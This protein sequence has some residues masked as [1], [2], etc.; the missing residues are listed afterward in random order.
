MNLLG[1]DI[2][3]T[4]TKV[5]LQA[6]DGGIVERLE[7]PTRAVEGPGALAARLAELFAKWPEAEGAG[8]SVAGLMDREK[9]L[10][11]APNLTEFVGTD[12]RSAFE[13]FGVLALE[14]DVNCAVYGEWQVG[15]GRG[16]SDLA[17][18]SLG[19]GVGGG[20]ILGGEL[21]HGS[22][23]LGAELGHMTL[24]PE[25]PVCPCGLRGHV[26]SWLGS[27]GFAA[28][29]RR[30]AEAAPDSKLAAAIGNGEEPDA[31][32]L[33]A[34]GNEGCAVAREALAECGRWLGIAC[35]NIV[36][37]L[38]PDR[39]LIAGGSARCGELLLGPAL[40]EYDQRCM[41]A[42][43][44]TVEVRVAELGVESAAIGAALLA[45]ANLDADRTRTR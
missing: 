14:N 22:G 15:A 30:H 37:V 23:G 18:L 42:A 4:N 5:I 29:A 35:A 7:V 31:R 20:L 27:Q 11:Q 45:R 40:R 24:D 36:A 43:R 1:I 16:A 34:V 33:S 19:T 26:E 17:M 8:I 39:I 9:N 41:D 13:G 32:L 3:G 12:L 25:G 6:A 10:V 21:F 2:G 28:V 38:Q 44:G